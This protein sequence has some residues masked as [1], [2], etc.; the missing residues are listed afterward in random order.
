MNISSNHLQNVPVI[1]AF[2]HLAFMIN[3]SREFSYKHGGVVNSHDVLG[4]R[5]GEIILFLFFNFKG[6]GLNLA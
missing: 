2:E 3:K 6:S 4:Q 5:L 1:A